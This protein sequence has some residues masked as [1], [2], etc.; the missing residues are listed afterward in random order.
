MTSLVDRINAFRQ[1]Y[2][3]G[4]NLVEHHV[5]NS[6]VKHNGINAAM[7]N[8]PNTV[9]NVNRL[10]LNTQF[11]CNAAFCAMPNTFVALILPFQEIVNLL[12]SIQDQLVQEQL[13]D[14]SRMPEN[15]TVCFLRVQTYLK[16]TSGC[17]HV[18][19]STCLFSWYLQEN[20]C[21][22]CRRR[23]ELNADNMRL[24]RN[25]CCILFLVHGYVE[26]VEYNYQR[27]RNHNNNI[28]SNELDQECKLN[29]EAFIDIIDRI[30][31]KLNDD[32]FNAVTFNQRIFSNLEFLRL[33]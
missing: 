33:P 28:W 18:V 24:T 25:I 16:A 29:T 32:E 6:S 5:V 31:R 12:D 26:L 10:N 17:N 20:T 30:G 14:V 7:N 4:N 8:N 15:C 9:I 23:S 22:Y 1:Q 21:P 11:N 13:V 3:V 27:R 19:H 2:P